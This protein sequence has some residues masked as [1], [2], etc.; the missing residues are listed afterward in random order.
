[1]LSQKIKM[2]KA[3]YLLGNGNRSK[4]EMYYILEGSKINKGGFVELFLGCLTRYS[5]VFKIF[6]DSRLIDCLQKFR[7]LFL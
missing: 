7:R 1:M 4:C 3:Q 6:I 2:R 5:K